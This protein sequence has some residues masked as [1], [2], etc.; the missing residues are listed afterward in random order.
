MI[1][2]V[3]QKQTLSTY[4]KSCSDMLYGLTPVQVRALAFEMAQANK[5]KCPSCWIEQKK[6]GRDWLTGF[7]KR[8]L[9]LSV[10]KPEA[11]SIARASAFNRYT[12]DIFFNKLQE[13]IS[14]SKA[15]SF[16]IFNLDETGFTTV[17]KTPR[18]I[19]SKRSK[20]VGQITS[21]ERGEL[22]TVCC[23]VSTAD[24][25]IPPVIVF[26]RKLFRNP[27]MRGAPEGSI[28][29][30]NQSVWMNAE[31]FID[32][33]KHFVKFA[34]PTADHKVLLIIDNHESHLSLQSL[35]YAKENHVCMM[36]LPPH[37]SHKTQPLDRSVFGPI[38]TY[39]NAAANSWMLNNPGQAIT[40][41][42]MAS[43][44]RQAW[45]KSSTPTNIMSGFRMT[46]IWPY[47]RH[48]YRDDI[49]L[50]SVVTDRDVPQ[51]P[52]NEGSN[53]KSNTSAILSDISGLGVQ[54]EA[55]KENLTVFSPE[56]VRG[57]PKAPSRKILRRGR[58]K[59][60]CMIATSA[61]QILRIKNE[62]LNKQKG[63]K[64][65]LLKSKNVR[66]N[67]L[68][69]SNS[70]LNVDFNKITND[71]SANCYSLEFEEVLETVFF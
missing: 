8:S 21:R 17:Q 71:V 7:L 36:T 63:K 34:R 2:S 10:R 47:D 22:V 62:V 32:V 60:K 53:E 65:V 46:G 56:I 49:F 42:K 41:Y 43:L 3:A 5:I 68:R 61:P 31:I 35:E 69:K 27:L 40:I 57:Y 58:K 29:L 1:F 14:E 51:E 24:V 54:H 70:D 66:K 16:K 44:I 64:I 45:E 4:L 15:T 20:Q 23:I 30:A 12:I 38:K 59:G 6:A 13:G 37:T 11:T 50:P 28:G 33:L 18:V 39:F 48:V 55:V 67:I 25:A 19:A 9:K 26:P 52:C